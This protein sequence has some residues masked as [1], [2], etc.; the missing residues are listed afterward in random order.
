MGG[1]TVNMWEGKGDIFHQ[2]HEMVSHANLLGEMGE[3]IRK[4]GEK[5]R[6]GA[7]SFIYYKLNGISRLS[8]FLCLTICI[9][10]TFRLMLLSIIC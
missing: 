7:N 2:T 6:G 10:K 1:A 9:F 3:Q 4:F 8:Y 5:E